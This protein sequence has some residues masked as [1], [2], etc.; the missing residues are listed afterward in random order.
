MLLL[1]KVNMNRVM[2]HEKERCS[3][4]EERRRRRS[5]GFRTRSGCTDFIEDPFVM[6][7]KLLPVFEKRSYKKES[8]HQPRVKWKKK[9]KKKKNVEA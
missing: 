1:I 7:S 9:N 6:L 3:A 2:T 5:H 8:Q 4:V